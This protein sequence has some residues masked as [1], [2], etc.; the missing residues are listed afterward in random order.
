MSE[1]ERDERVFL[2][3]IHHSDLTWQ[4]SYEEYDRI[5]EKQLNRVM[6][7]FEKHPGYGFV[8]DQAYVLQN[9][10][11]RNPDKLE[12][13]KK[14]FDNG[15]GALELIGGYSIPDMN[16]P[17][18]ES[19]LR[20]CMLAREYY[21]KEFQFTPDTAS[22]MDAFGTPFQTPQMLS[23]LG[24]RYLAPGRMPNGPEDLDVD[25][26][27]VW[28]GAAGSS[29]VV[30]P[31]NAGIDNTSY[32]T[33]VPVLRNEDE[34]FAETLR[35]L[36]HTKG[37]VLAY[38]MTE[39]QLLDES[40]FR[41]MEEVNKDPDAPRKVHFG[42]LKDYCST[43][44]EQLLPAYQGEFNPVFSG[45]YTTR[46]GVKQAIRSAENAL[47]AAELATALVGEMPDLHAAWEQLSLGVFHDAACGCHHDSSNVDVM[48]KLHYAKK[49]AEKVLE[50]ATGVGTAVAV[51]NPS[52][53]SGLQMIETTAACLPAGLPV[54]RDGDRCYFLAPLPAYSIQAFPRADAD[55][56]GTGKQ[57]PTAGYI[58]QTDYYRFDFTSSMPKITTRRFDKTVF[59]Q[60]NFGEILFRHESGTLWSE[61][62]REVPYGAEYQDEK[63]TSVEDGPVF[64]KVTIEG[65]VRPG[66]TPISGNSGD[67]WPGFEHLSFKKEYCFPKHLPYFRL[68]VTVNFAGCR[69]KISL[70]IPVELDPLKAKALYHTPFAATERKPYFE[71]PYRYRETAHLLRSG[72]YAYAKGDYPALHWI[73]YSDGNIGLAVANNGTPGCQLVGK[74]IL[75]SL[76]RSGTDCLGGTMYPQPG[77]YDN[78]EHVFDFVFTDHE[79]ANHEAAIAA[80]EILNRAPVCISGAASVNYPSILTI[81]KQN[82]VVSA[83]YRDNDNL[84]LRAYECMGKSTQCSINCGTLECYASDLYGNSGERLD[85]GSVAFQPFEIRTFVL[86]E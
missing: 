25:A 75:V 20:N 47:F 40:F 18:G 79:G 17:S 33:N 27:F 12:L 38:Y 19:F 84:V 2:T 63:V 72:A 35:N 36:Q 83:I 29:V 52:S 78:G 42:R 74:E 24:Y 66:K 54:Q 55:V 44:N 51:L 73:D 50:E 32:V 69:T 61:E 1:N 46:I 23:L 30:V 11:Q 82:I 58:G 77:S 10:L 85:K 21:E 56:A 41:H 65:A 3:T 67:Y 53:N 45:C 14:Y 22:L 15:N 26:P 62:I 5:R 43:L 9:Y 37:N 34:R 7:F 81:D 28:K 59:G 80:G 64:I 60:E 48:Q 57:L 8:F 70:R 76:L 68:R 31:Q 39:F 4:F 6:D 71:V 86:K 13:I 16:I 49:A